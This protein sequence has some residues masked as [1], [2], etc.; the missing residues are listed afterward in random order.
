MQLVSNKLLGPTVI[1]ITLAQTLLHF[2]DEVLAVFVQVVVAGVITGTT[3]VGNN[4]RGR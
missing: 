4:G 1:A 3:G 2:Y